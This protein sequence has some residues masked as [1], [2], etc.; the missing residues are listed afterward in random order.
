MDETQK[1]PLDGDDSVHSQ[2]V[3]PRRHSWCCTLLYTQ[4]YTKVLPSILPPY[5]LTNHCWPVSE[6]CNN[7]QMQ[8]SNFSC[9]LMN[10]QALQVVCSCSPDFYNTIDLVWWVQNSMILKLLKLFSQALFE[11]KGKMSDLTCMRL[12]QHDMHIVHREILCTEHIITDYL[13]VEGWMKFWL[14]VLNNHRLDLA[15]RKILNG[16]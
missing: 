6:N 15:L 2:T 12:N 4:N 7:C 16:L 11:L 1:K 9:S 3:F 13:V 14:H 5:T 10:R 8:S